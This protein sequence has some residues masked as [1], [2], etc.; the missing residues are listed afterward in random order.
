MTKEQILSDL[1]FASSVARAGAAT[2]LLGG[3]IGLMWGVLLTLI[4]LA[5]WAI[6]SDRLAIEHQNI[7]LLWLAFVVLG[8]IG[9]TVLGRKIDE[10]PGANSVANRVEAYVWIMFSGFMATLFF[11]VVLN[12]VLKGATPEMFDFIV[13]A[14]FAGQGLAYGE[15]DIESINVYSSQTS[16]DIRRYHSLY[17]VSQNA[18]RKDAGKGLICLKT[19]PLFPSLFRFITKRKMSLSSL[20]KSL[21]RLM[22]NAMRWCL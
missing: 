2:P 7:W 18:M 17:C 15:I 1:D 10:K 9:S 3:P 20:M 19:I 12:M 14:G 16:F 8:G 11:G 6:L 5:Q 21:S 22:P 4:F 13:I